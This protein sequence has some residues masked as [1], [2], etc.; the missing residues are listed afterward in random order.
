MKYKHFPMHVA[1]QVKLP[2]VNV[3]HMATGKQHQ[4][5]IVPILH[6]KSHHSSKAPS[7]WQALS[8]LQFFE[9]ASKLVVCDVTIR[10]A[11]KKYTTRE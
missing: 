11:C 1:M 2:K 3:N 10:G 9:L 5:A 8:M 6:L 7:E 4:V